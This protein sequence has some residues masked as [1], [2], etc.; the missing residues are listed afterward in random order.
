MNSRGNMGFGGYCVCHK[1]GYR[2]NHIQG[3]RCRNKTCPLCKTVL[4]RE[5][6]YHYNLIM[7]AEN[8]K[9]GG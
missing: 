6:S 4:V 2:E 3:E 1:C 8:K 5:G 9:K 7:E